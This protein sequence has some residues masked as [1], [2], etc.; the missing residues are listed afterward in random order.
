[1]K[2]R[3]SER[4]NAKIK[5]AIQAPSGA[6]K[7]YS[8]L[9]IAK[10]LTNDQFTKVAIIDT[11]NGSADLYSHLGEY[12]VLPLQPPYTP[13]NYIKAIELCEKE[14]MEVI[15]IDSI[16]HCWD[17]LLEY[18]S[19]LPG[20]SFTNWGKI[21]PRQN[22]FVQ[23][24]LQSSSHIISTMRVKQ[25]Y[26]LNNRNG[27]MVP[28]KVGLKA[29]QRDSVDYEFTV[30]FDLDMKHYAKSSKDRTGLFSNK[31]EF[32]ITAGVGKRIN[33]WCNSG[34]DL[35]EVKNKIKACSTNEALNK[36][37]H[38]YAVW[39][40]VLNTDFIHQQEKI[41]KNQ[42][43]NLNNISNNGTTNSQLS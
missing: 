14:G 12:N 26:V 32:I 33:E 6:G 17:Y 8:S 19:S 37:Y 11:E 36:L 28:E 13:E 35:V 22:A 7:T 9:L 10:G 23:K 18:H 20:N 41:N 30:V 43:S 2:L 27:K 3:K 29:V 1:M 16:S 5:M 34:T 15:I 25:D 31:P 24:M 42:M 40:N 21:T 39:K 38:K 4:K